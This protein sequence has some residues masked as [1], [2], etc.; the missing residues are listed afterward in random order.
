MKHLW[1]VQPITD[2]V[3]SGTAAVLYMC[4]DKDYDVS[5]RPLDELAVS[6]IAFIR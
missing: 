5:K 2:W 1:R 6:Q 4:R 3:G